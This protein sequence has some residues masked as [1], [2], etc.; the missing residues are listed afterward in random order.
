[1]SEI[2]RKLPPNEFTE[3]TIGDI[4]TTDSG[5][6][7]KLINVINVSDGDGK[8]TYYAWVPLSENSGKEKKTV[9]TLDDKSDIKAYAD[10]GDGANS[11][12]IVCCKGAVNAPSEFS[13][14]NTGFYIIIRNDDLS[15]IKI[16]AFNTLGRSFYILS[17]I[18]GTWGSY[19]YRIVESSYPSD[20]EGSIKLDEIPEVTKGSIRYIMR[21]GI[22]HVSIS[23]L[24]LSVQNKDITITTKGLPIA[25]YASSVPLFDGTEISGLAKIAIARGMLKVRSTVAGKPMTGSFSYPVH[26]PEIL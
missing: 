6:Q 19:W 15:S 11:Y 26:E 1:M 12:E 4:C 22:C 9:K 20:Y 21:N 18:D 8:R 25:P 10:A 14:E 16:L 17:K 3:G 23:N 2:K 5:D 13:E 24:T 7:Y